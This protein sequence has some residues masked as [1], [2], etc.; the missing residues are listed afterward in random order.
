MLV[1][2]TPNGEVRIKFETLRPLDQDTVAVVN[3]NATT[4]TIKKAANQQQQQQVVQDKPVKQPVDTIV[5]KGN[6]APTAK[7]QQLAKAKAIKAEKQQKQQQQLQQ[8]QQ[9][10]LDQEMADNEQNIIMEIDPV[11]IK[12]EQAMILTPE[13]ATIMSSG[14]L[15]KCSFCGR[16]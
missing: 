11:N 4:T 2:D 14:Q 7:Q 5:I 10:Q 16:Q 3:S 1:L 15:G 9:D 6:A 8:Q 13:M 12:S